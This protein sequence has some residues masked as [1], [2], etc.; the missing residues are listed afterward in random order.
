MTVARIQDV[1]AAFNKVGQDYSDLREDTALVSDAIAPLNNPDDFAA[2]FE[3][4]AGGPASPAPVFNYNIP[5]ANYAE[6]VDAAT[7]S[8]PFSMRV[9]WYSDGNILEAIR[10]TGGPLLG[11][12]WAPAGVCRLGHFDPSLPAHERILAA[13]AYVSANPG[14][15]MGWDGEVVD[16]ATDV[17]ADGLP[18]VK[19][20]VI[21]APPLFRIA[22]Q[23]H[24]VFSIGR[25]CPDFRWDGD[26]LAECTI[27]RVKGS[28]RWG[29]LSAF[30]R[31]SVLW[32][33]A[34]RF[35]HVGTIRSANFFNTVYLRG[36][37]KFKTG[38]YPN[39]ANYGGTSVAM[40]DDRENMVGV[41][42]G[43]IRA[44]QQDFALMGVQHEGTEVQSVWLSD[45]TVVEGIDPHAVYI[46]GSTDQTDGYRAT[47]RDLRIGEIRGS[48]NTYSMPF[49]IRDTASATIGTV[50]AYRC[51]GAVLIGERCGDVVVE[52]VLSIAQ[53]ERGDTPAVPS[54]TTVDATSGGLVTVG[55]VV[56]FGADGQQIKPLEARFGSRLT[57]GR[58]TARMAMDSARANYFGAAQEGC[59][60]SI[61][62]ADLTRYLPAGGVATSTRDNLFH[63]MG[64]ANVTVSGL[65]Y[66]GSDFYTRIVRQRGTG[67][68]RA[69]YDSGLVEGFE[70]RHPAEADTPGLVKL[71]DVSGVGRFGANRFADRVRALGRSTTGSAIPIT[72]S[73][74]GVPAPVY[75]ADVTSAYAFTGR[76]VARQA[77]DA[78]NVAVWDVR[79]AITR[80]STPGATAL[81]GVSITLISSTAG[82]ASWAPPTLSAETALGGLSITSGAVA[83]TIDWTA[84]LEF[85]GST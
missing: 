32:I 27:T 11:G 77:V 53:V 38:E 45:Q 79:G 43:H 6:A 26:I 41:S 33:E 10:V 44:E 13:W 65:E 1:A 39:W 40:M 63:A 62:H 73:G 68:F 75:I 56:A 51:A 30:S 47:C 42:I 74:D 12:G 80:G 23:G 69:T 66:R 34:D 71:N 37:V 67:R 25:G 48:D 29:G 81:E 24:G 28:G 3:A 8:P 64:G 84:Q 72:L 60:L 46:T 54:S 4:A 20:R 82:A 7:N 31:N 55:S 5:F 49:K 35:T 76:I 50:S 61:G 58:L 15:V 21:G 36:V 85:L 14:T 22:S 52:S 18:N 9:S 16:L 19:N 57:V 59:S 78:N 83:G 2:I 70:Q 17:R